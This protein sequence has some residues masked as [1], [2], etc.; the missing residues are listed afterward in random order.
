MRVAIIVPAIRQL[1][2]VI[3]MKTLVNSLK[4]Y[5]GLNV[6]VF[7]LDKNIDKKVG[8]EVPVKR[9]KVRTFHFEDYDIIHTNGIRPDLIA[10]LYRRRIK[11]HIT[12]IHNF[13]FDDLRY[14]YNRFISFI[15]GYLW[16]IVWSRADKLVCISETMRSYYK[17]WY[18]PNKLEVI[19]N[20]ISPEKSPNVLDEEV[21]NI[22]KSFKLRGLKVIGTASILTGRKGVEQILHLIASQLEY[23][24]VIIG[25]GK[26]KSN[27]ENLSRRL[28]I[29][30]RCFFSGFCNN[31]KN[32]FHLF[33]IFIMPSRSEGF[34]LALIEAVQ[35]K[36]PVICSDIEVFKELFNNDEVTFFRLDNKN[37]M[38]D[39]LKR[40]VNPDQR[41]PL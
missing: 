30:D 6:E 24:A 16:L 1:G 15:F 34:G 21:V 33:D 26:E 40:S 3:V 39:A 8:M 13:V 38:I 10:F 14:T 19:H 4:E 11:Y 2:P 12:T 7:Y 20:G 17:K 35:Q 23:A 25:D 22:I 9:M 27:L 41:K 5:P 18:S 28:L 37:S 36:V 32:Y 31:A 29:S